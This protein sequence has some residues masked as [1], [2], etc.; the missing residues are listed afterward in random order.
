MNFKILLIASFA[1]V[2]QV[3]ANNFACVATSGNYG[4]ACHGINYQGKMGSYITYYIHFNYPVK[5]ECQVLGVAI[6]QSEPKCGPIN[7]IPVG[8]IEG[9]SIMMLWDASHTTPGISCKADGKYDI[10]LT[11]SVTT[12]DSSSLTC[13]NR[14]RN[15]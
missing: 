4:P 15:L 10:P 11:W 6:Y 8:D 14:D 5:I 7:W 13:M 12:G 9:R 2:N 3:R 1:L